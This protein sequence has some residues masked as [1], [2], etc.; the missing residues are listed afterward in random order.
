MLTA[1]DKK[2]ISAEISATEDHTAAPLTA[3]EQ[4]IGARLEKLQATLI[5]EFRKWM[6]PACDDPRV[7]AAALRTIDLELEALQED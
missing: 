1:D 7:E 2:W 6:L 4:R 5:A 3:R